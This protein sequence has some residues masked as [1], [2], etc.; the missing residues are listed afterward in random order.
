MSTFIFGGDAGRFA[1]N[2]CFLS[3]HWRCGTRVCVIWGPSALGLAENPTW[4]QRRTMLMQRLVV[5]HHHCRDMPRPWL[6]RHRIW[7]FHK[8]MRHGP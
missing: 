2:S 1:I 8:Q 7:L 5:L 4:R 6:R 3:D